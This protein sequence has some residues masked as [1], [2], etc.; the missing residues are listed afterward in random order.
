MVEYKT[1]CRFSKYVGGEIRTHGTLAEKLV[2]NTIYFL[3]IPKD[4]L[5]SKEQS[6]PE[7]AHYFTLQNL[8]IFAISL[9][10]VSIHTRTTQIEIQVLRYLLNPLLNQI[11]SG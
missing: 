5:H 10:Q 3:F 11:K 9:Y 6:C 4:L 2:F 1:L 7:V 8:M